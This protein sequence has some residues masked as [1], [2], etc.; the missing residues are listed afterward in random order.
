MKI[1]VCAGADK[2][3]ILADA[4]AEFIELGVS[5]AISPLSEESEW[6]EK[7]KVFLALPISTETFNV[8][9]PGNLRITGASEQLA[10]K[11]TVRHYVFNALRRV[12]GIGGKVIVFGSGGARRVSDGFSREQA[13]EQI[14]DFLRLCAEASEETGVVIAIEPLNQGECNIINTVAEAVTE[15]AGIL[16]HPGIRVLA[17]TYHMEIEN[18]PISVIQEYAPF[19]AHVHTADTKRVVPGQGVYDHVALFRLLNDINYTGR[20]SVEANFTNI[21]SQ[22]AGVMNHLREAKKQRHCE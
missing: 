19:I 12:R 7:Q 18:E 6:T 21:E 10:D 2:A 13:A 17:D 16:N 4:G 14:R 9:L 11:D 5:N 22:I 20:V 15:Y 8:F 1:G 3:Q